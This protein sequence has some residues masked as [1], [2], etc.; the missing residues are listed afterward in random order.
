MSKIHLHW[1]S[2]LAQKIH[3]KMSIYINIKRIDAYLRRFYKQG[4][5][6]VYISITIVLLWDKM[7][8][9]QQYFC[10]KVDKYN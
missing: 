2:I 8:K 6:E 10:T 9:I 4:N 1:V 3:L 5:L 7:K